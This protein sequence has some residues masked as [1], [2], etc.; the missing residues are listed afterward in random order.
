MTFLPPQSVA[1]VGGGVF[2]AAVAFRLARS[3]VPVTVVERDEPGAHASGRNAGH[4]NP[5]HLTPEPLVP[6]ALASF[7]LHRRLRESLETLGHG[8]CGWEPIRRIVVAFEPRETL[9]FAV[10][11]RR[12]A[13]H[14]GFTAR[15]LDVAALRELEPRI[16]RRAIGGLL[17][18]GS[19]SVD[20]RALTRALVAAAVGCGARV[21]RAA[22]TGVVAAG[23]RVAAVCTTAGDVPCDHAIF[24]TGAWV[25]G[26]AA[27]LGM[28]SIVRPVQGQLLRV[29]V[30]GGIGCDLVHEGDALYRR[31]DGEVWIGGTEDD[32]G[33]DES[34]TAAA[35]ARLL[36]GAERLMPGLGC[37]E[38]LEHTCALRP[39][40]P[41]R[42]PLVVQPARW[43]NVIV[44][45]GGG[46]K[47]VLLAPGVAERVAASLGILD[48]MTTPLP[49]VA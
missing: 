5:L 45:N 4:L 36:A 17:L 21:V 13:A 9:A 10:L 25:D 16:S 44:A 47:G 23:S 29:R 27:W 38:V 8:G 30:A 49:L 18:E 3:G 42:L 37:T 19:M 48:A 22:A 15:R 43:T 14:A 35:R 6:F 32:A 40:A 24:A 20:A 33:L 41:G 31:G 11:E 12:F 1:I 28:R 39:M 34:P 2:G 7:H 46:S 26:P